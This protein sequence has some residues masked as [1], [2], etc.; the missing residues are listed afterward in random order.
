MP[1]IILFKSDDNISVSFSRWNKKQ[2]PDIRAR[3]AV[4]DSV[5]Q[6]RADPALLEP[7]QLTEA[8]RGST[9]MLQDQVTVAR[10]LGKHVAVEK[11]P[12][13]RPGTV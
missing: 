11:V 1:N 8:D 13:L 9:V 7:A 3:A 5:K 4:L 6:G 2:F 12:A 10:D